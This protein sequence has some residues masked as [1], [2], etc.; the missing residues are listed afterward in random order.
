MEEGQ[1][2]FSG[3]RGTWGIVIVPFGADGWHW[4]TRGKGLTE[5]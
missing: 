1:L 4:R 3:E 2:M 5:K